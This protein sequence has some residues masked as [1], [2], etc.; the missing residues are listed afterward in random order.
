MA[1][2]LIFMGTPQ[3]AV[4][5]LEKLCESAFFNIK[6]VITQPDRPAGRGK[7]LTPP[8]VK[9]KA[10]EYG[11]EI[12]QPE[13]K[14]ELRELVNRLEFNCIAVVAYGMILPRE[15]IEKPK[16]GA[17]N[18][19]ASLLPKYRG[20]APIERA[21][22]SGEKIT[23]NTI[24]LI[25]EG[26]DEGD[27][28]ARKEIII[29]DKDNRATLAEKLSTEGSHLLVNTLEKWIGG[30]IKPLPQNHSEA[31]YAPLIRKEEFRIC[32]KANAV[33]IRDKVRAFY[34]NAYTFFRGIVIKVFSCEPVEG[35]GFP[36]EILDNRKFIVACGEGALE[37]RELISPKGKKVRGEDFVR[38]YGNIKGEVLK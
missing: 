37:I 13:S 26:M 27:I 2:D 29:E 20:P 18:L 31:T 1:V 25:N 38:G 5:S 30:D 21:I 6:A 22:L 16:Y 33:S 8:P 35:E 28:L 36:G 15:V 7:R 12:Y 11:I 3:F 23:G 4:P 24:I 19:H 34:P 17:V 14:K 9:L 32:W 10:L